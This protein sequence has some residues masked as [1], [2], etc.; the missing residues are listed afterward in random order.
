M[1]LAVGRFRRMEGCKKPW[2]TPDSLILDLILRLPLTV[3][4]RLVEGGGLSSAPS[5]LAS[6]RTSGEGKCAVTMPG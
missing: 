5:G 2:S 1:K 4:L 3:R 6:Q